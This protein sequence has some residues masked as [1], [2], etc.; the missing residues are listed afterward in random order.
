MCGGKSLA[1]GRSGVEVRSTFSSL[2]A[3]VPR[4]P[5]RTRHLSLCLAVSLSLSM[6]ISP[7]FDSYEVIFKRSFLMRLINL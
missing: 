1:N 5:Q 3:F 4:D 6:T 2:L 7:M